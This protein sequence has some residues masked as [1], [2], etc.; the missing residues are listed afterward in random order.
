MV[1]SW[2]CPTLSEATRVS[3]AALTSRPTAALHACM[4]SDPHD[5]AP[6][7]EHEPILPCMS[8]PHPA[9]SAHLECISTCRSKL[10]DFAKRPTPSP[11]SVTE[12]H[13]RGS[14]RM[15]VDR[16]I[17]VEIEEYKRICRRCRLHSRCTRA[18]VVL[19]HLCCNDFH[20]VFDFL[21]SFALWQTLVP[22]RHARHFP[23]RLLWQHRLKLGR[24]RFA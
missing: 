3:A 1:P 18:A 21:R 24:R 11:Q 6:S 16:R 4:H 12:H 13:S 23:S 14:P 7:H 10:V 20:C 22:C 19:T 5:R 2:S 8:P 15:T 17:A 9:G